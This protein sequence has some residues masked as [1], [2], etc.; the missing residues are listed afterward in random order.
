[1][2]RIK[3]I[4]YALYFGIMP[5]WMYEKE[6]HYRCSWYAHL[7]INLQYAYRWITFRETHSDRKFERKT[8]NNF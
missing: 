3:A 1:M 4:L 2:I 7:V 8:N 6:R 5:Y